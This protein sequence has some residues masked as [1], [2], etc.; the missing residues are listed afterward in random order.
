VS[1]LV[2]RVSSGLRLSRRCVSGLECGVEQVS[3]RTRQDAE[4]VDEGAAG[5]WAVSASMTSVSASAGLVTV[6]VS[7]VSAVTAYVAAVF[8]CVSV[9]LG[10]DTARVRYRARAVTHRLSSMRLVNNCLRRRAGLL[11]EAFHLSG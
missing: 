8:S 9:W 4:E 2:L 11:S 1:A 7:V 6:L 5:A 10:E 3:V